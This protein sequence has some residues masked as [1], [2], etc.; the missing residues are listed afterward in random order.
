MADPLR[1]MLPLQRATLDNIGRLGP[2]A[3]LT[4]PAVRGDA[5]TISMNLE[6]LSQALPGAVP[7]YV[8][9]AEA[10]LDIA[11]HA[12]RLPADRRAAVEEVLRR[13]R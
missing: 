8:A 1:A 12:D 6:A 3:A 2:E 7:A 9:M 4:G 13:W 11:T 10:T 5:G